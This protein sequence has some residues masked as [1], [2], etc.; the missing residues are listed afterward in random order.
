V[1]YADLSRL[2]QIARLRPLALAALAQYPIEP[3]RVRLL[4]HG[5]N[6]TY[7][8]DSADGRRFALRL[9]VLPRKTVANLDAEMAWLAALTADTGVPVPVPLAT[10]EGALHTSVHSVMLGGDV[11][12]VMMSWLPGPDLE[13]LTVPA[14]RALGRLAAA[15]HTHAEGWELPAGAELPAIDTVLMNVPYQLDVDHPLLTPERRR[16]FDAAFAHVQTRYDSLLARSPRLALHADLHAG[17]LKWW[18]GQMAVFDFDD[19]GIGAP[20][21]DLAIAAYYLRPQA[22][23]EQ[24][25]LDGYQRVR[26]L[27]D[28]TADE[29]EAVVASRNLVLLNDVVTTE[30]AEFRAMLPAYVANTATKLRAYL[31][32]GVYRHDVGGLLPL[33]D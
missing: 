15:L 33:S 17:N 18:R 4:L 12:V 20:A 31:E 13:Q 29:F 23:V 32:T 22:E 5:Y 16:V 26:P 24:A 7:R 9:N 3:T 8:V 6:T 10:R 11:P 19:A 30:H 27:P 2:A 21:Q 1:A 28:V 14:G 25:M